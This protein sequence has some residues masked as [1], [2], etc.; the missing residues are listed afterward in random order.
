MSLLLSLVAC[1]E[2]PPLAPFSEV[3]VAKEQSPLQVSPSL[4]RIKIPQPRRYYVSPK[5]DDDNEGRTLQTP[6]RS[7]KEAVSRVLPGET[8]FLREGRY[9]GVSIKRPGRA[10]AWINLRAF[11][12]ESVVIE[13][14]GR[15]QALYFYND[16]FKPMY[17]SVEGLEVVGGKHYVVKIDTPFVHL[18]RNK[19]H[20]SKRD[21]VKLVHTADDVVIYGNEIYSPDA[22]LGANAQGVD[23]V[24]AARTW[25]ARNVV[26]DIPSIGMYA[27]GNARDTVFEGNLLRNI[28]ERGIMLGQSTDAERLRDGN[29]ES[30]DGIIRNNVIINTGEACLA[31]ASSSGVL[32]YNNSCYNASTRA[33][34]AIFL[35]NESEVGQ[36]GE[37]ITIKNNIVHVSSAKGRPAVK[38]S[39]N[40]LVDPKTLELDNNLYWTDKGA[41]L[42]F[43]W[44]QHGLEK[45]S[46]KRWQQK[47]GFD[48][49]SEIKDPLFADLNVLKLKQGSPALE[50]AEGMD[51]LLTDFSGVSR[52]DRQHPDLGAHER[53][54]RIGEL[55]PSQQKE[56]MPRKEAKGILFRY[57]YLQAQSATEV[58]ILWGSYAAGHGLLRLWKKGETTWRDFPSRQQHFAKQETGLK[59]DFE[60]HLV[61]L[62]DL[63]PDTEY[64]FDL[65]HNGLLLASAVS[66]KT[67]PDASSKAVNFIAFGDSGTKYSQP[68]KVRDAISSRENGIWKYPHDFSIGVGDIAYSSGSYKQFDQKFFDQLSGKGKKQPERGILMHRPF[69]SSLGNHEYAN[70]EQNLPK[71]YLASFAYPSSTGMPEEDR[72]RYFSF[73]SGPVH[74]VVLDSMKFASKNSERARLPQMLAWM[75]ADLKASQQPWKLVLF[76]HS[77]LS[78]EP[79]GTY[80]D[81]SENRRMRQKLFPRLQKLGV[82]FVLF[83]HDHM[84]QRTQP[85]KFDADGQIIRISGGKIDTQEGITYIGIG[86]GGA[87]LHNRSTQPSEYESE[88]WLE[89][90]RKWGIGYDF[91]ARRADGQPVLFD[92]ANKGD[93]EPKAPEK[94]WGFTHIQVQ[95]DELK[96]VAYNYLHEVMDEFVLRR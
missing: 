57:P 36:A 62:F 71:G 94:R 40:A 45:V 65:L 6:L 18:I 54:H 59:Q 22:K 37:N 55:Q 43:N 72:E 35:S 42:R 50:R 30:Y 70:K 49:N 1:G 2:L 89:Q 68:R 26:H 52:F 75:E 19:L 46:L 32:I 69:F 21:I 79:H 38:I 48:L 25:V 58:K 20:G 90:K 56:V 39:S 84:Y 77:P 80:G 13:A 41:K 83:G 31:S 27:K 66:F 5:G 28:Y 53:E 33:H 93:D 85:L 11:G 73:D 88:L 17:W 86:N 87:D 95:G 15:T 76:H 34:G 74:F 61:Q 44:E 7:L 24:G 64:R 81:R 51:G 9:K 67:L 63:E 10:D 16:D 4:G 78:F 92:N 91:I 3:A 96:V 29:F 8:I 12:N 23:I 47:T 82:Q 60:Q 14:Q